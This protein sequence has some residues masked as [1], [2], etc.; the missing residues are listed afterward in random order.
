MMNSE[1]VLKALK[2][3]PQSVKEIIAALG[4]K[5]S[6]SNIENV[7]RSLEQEGKAI[8]EKVIPEQKGKGHDL[9]RRPRILWR[10]GK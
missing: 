7:L 1:T 9:T 2:N 6:R 5:H 4:H 3:T 8:R 10:R